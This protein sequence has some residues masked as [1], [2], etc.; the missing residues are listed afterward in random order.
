MKKQNNALVVLSEAKQAVADKKAAKL[1][2]ELVSRL[3]EVEETQKLL[4]D[5]REELIGRLKEE[6]LCEKDVLKAVNL[7]G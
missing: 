2:E 5:L 7:I 1:K 6:G 4:A 3:M